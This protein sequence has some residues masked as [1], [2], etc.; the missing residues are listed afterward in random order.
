MSMFKDIF[1]EYPHRSDKVPLDEGIGQTIFKFRGPSE[2]RYFLSSYLYRDRISVRLR[3][4]AHDCITA[5][6]RYIRAKRW[7][8]ACEK[9]LARR[10]LAKAQWELTVKGAIEATGD[11][12]IGN[13]YQRALYREERLRS[14]ILCS[15]FGKAI[16]A[17]VCEYFKPEDKS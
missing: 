4:F 10:K 11:P 17:G 9:E 14:K 8:K 16:F 7:N 5:P 2:Q 1:K 12:E 6:S 3:W 13:K 15:D